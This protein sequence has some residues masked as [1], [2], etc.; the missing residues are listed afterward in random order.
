MADYNL[1]RKGGGPGYSKKAFVPTMPWA[2]DEERLDKCQDEIACLEDFY[3]Q[4]HGSNWKN[5]TNWLKPGVHFSKYNGITAV[6]G[7][8]VEIMLPRNNLSGKLPKS[9]KNLKFLRRLILEENAIEGKIPNLKGMKRL[10]M[11]HLFNNEIEGPLPQ[12]LA[13]KQKV[14]SNRPP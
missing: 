13:N 8:V 14:Q 3:M 7:H 11:L 10:T 2:V 1:V 4:L 6:N 5:S 12:S 9:L